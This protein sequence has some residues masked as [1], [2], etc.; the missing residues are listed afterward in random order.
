[1]YYHFAD[2]VLSTAHK[3]KGLEFDTVKLTDDY[4]N[5]MSDIGPMLGMPIQ[6]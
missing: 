5:N 4:M 1:M 2:I 3:S 6:N